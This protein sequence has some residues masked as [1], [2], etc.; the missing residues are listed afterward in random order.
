[1]TKC[2][3]GADLKVK[4]EIPSYSRVKATP[5]YSLEVSRSGGEVVAYIYLFDFPE[6]AQ[7][8]VDDAKLDAETDDRKPTIEQPG[9]TAVDW[10][11][12]ATPAIRAC[13]DQAAN[14][15]PD[16]ARAPGAQG[17][18]SRRRGGAYYAR[19]ARAAGGH[20]T[21]RPW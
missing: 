5:E 19:D 21:H 17:L 11:A 18:C 13:I 16:G 4:S 1:V 3:R 2:L 8:F 14:P 6:E 15:E 20:A 9:A 10:D 7:R 12:G